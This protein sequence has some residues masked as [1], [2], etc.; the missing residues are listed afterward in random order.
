MHVTTVTTEFRFLFF[1]TPSLYPLFFLQKESRCHIVTKEGK[2]A[3]MLAF[4]RD[5]ALS[6]VCHV[7][8][9]RL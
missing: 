9:M 4:G 6:Q 5:K 1:S 7:V 3:P 2:P 8:T